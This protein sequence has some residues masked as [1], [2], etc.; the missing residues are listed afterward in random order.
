MTSTALNGLWTYL[1]T[2]SLTERNRKW[3][4]EKLVEPAISPEIAAIPPQYRVDPYEVSPSGDPY[5]ADRRH[6]EALDRAISEAEKEL[7][8]GNLKPVNIDDIWK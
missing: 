6:V 7:K 3:L 4:A 5:W 1:Q 2:L 8:K